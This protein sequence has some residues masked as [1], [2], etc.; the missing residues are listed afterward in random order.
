MKNLRLFTAF[1]VA[2]PMLFGGCSDD[3]APYI[4][5]TEETLEV[6]N[7]GAEYTIDVEA[8]C[9]WYVYH[10]V[11]WVQFAEEPAGIGNGSFSISVKKNYTYED[12]AAKLFINGSSCSDTLVIRQKMGYGIVLS[13]QNNIQVNGYGGNFT[14]SINSNVEDIQVEMPDWISVPETKTLTGREYNFYAYLNDTKSKRYGTIKFSGKEKTLNVNVI[15]DVINPQKVYALPFPS[16]V[17]QFGKVEIPL[18]IY[19]ESASMMNVRFSSSNT[20]VCR[21]SVVGETLVLDYVGMGDAYIRCSVLNEELWNIKTTCYDAEHI[22]LW[23]DDGGWG[24]LSGDQVP[25]DANIPLSS[26]TFTTTTPDLVSISGNTIYALNEG[27][28]TIIATETN[29][30]AQFTLEVYINPAILYHQNQIISPDH[31]SGILRIRS[32][33]V[34]Y[35]E[36]M[37]LIDGN[38]NTVLSVPGF[39]LQSNNTT[40]VYWEYDYRPSPNVDWEQIGNYTFTVRYLFMDDFYS[41]ILSIPFHK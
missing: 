19:P 18:T 9:D 17:T 37:E 1:A 15:Q 22:S 34:I 41:R 7:E 29:T 31:Y 30:N 11:D 23:V 39:N 26:F 2:F 13:S 12:R 20:E 40:N 36:Q 10:D 33:E 6:E 25:I 24:V 16:V 32:N 8:N 35:V 21:V 5:I 28:A 3:E 27:V 38:G 4:T 14:I